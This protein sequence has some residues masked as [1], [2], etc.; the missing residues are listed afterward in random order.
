[1]SSSVFD[2]LAQR[3]DAWFDTPRGSAI[4]AAELA[5]LR[6]LM[7]RDTSGWVE[8]GVGSGRF[9]AALGIGEGVDP[10]SPMLQKAAA[11]GIK[12]IAAEAERLPYAS[13][14]VRGILLV[15]TLCFLSEP[16]IALREFVR[17]LKEGGKLLVG[18]VPSDS[19]WGE[20]Y[21]LKG[22]QGHPFY[23]VAHFYTCDE[24]AEMAMSAGLQLLGA[25]STLPMGPDDPLE[26]IPVL[27]GVTPGCGF[28]G[29][30]FGLRSPKP[31]L[32]ATTD[33]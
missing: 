8:V 9:A 15:V 24:V 10:S 28:V 32:D 27:E 11:R 6:R 5:C 25:A 21:R 2:R 23:S 30:L 18:I 26:D 19:S 16:A 14:S 20:Y 33:T 3:Y 13:R 22:S 31:S 17:V 7:P 12:T 29:M 4:L 1:M